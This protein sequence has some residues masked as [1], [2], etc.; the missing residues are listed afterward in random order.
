MI[1]KHQLM[2]MIL[3]INHSQQADQLTQYLEMYLY[4]YKTKLTH[5]S[6]E[7]SKEN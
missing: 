1:F 4:M 2:M 6:L 3:I 5:K 7:L